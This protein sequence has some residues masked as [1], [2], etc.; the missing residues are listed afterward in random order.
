MATEEILVIV[1]FAATMAVL[2]LGFPVAFTLAGSAVIFGAIGVLLDVFSFGLVGA[3]PQRVFSVMT[4]DVLIAAPLFIFMGVMLQR[5]AVAEELL[6]HIGYL[7]G[8]LRGGLGMSVTVVGMLLAASTG[9]IG[10]T[11][12]T[13]GLLSLPA[14]MKHRYDIRLA[15]G[16]I[17]AAGTLGQIIPPS[18]VLV[19]MGDFLGYSYQQAMFKLGKYDAGSVGIVEL[20]AG[21]L[22]PGW[23]WSGSI[24]SIR[25]R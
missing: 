25:W 22:L 24:S 19:F 14:L 1:M 11:V 3:F 6:E 9:V 20:F 13:L 16:T 8:R 5:S 23:C 18:L 4:T 21:A 7:F 10:A 12:V 15:C 2:L 17:T